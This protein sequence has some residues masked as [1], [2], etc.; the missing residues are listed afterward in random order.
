MHGGELVEHGPG[1]EAG[2]QR[3]EPCAQGDM[4]A[5][6]PGRRGRCELRY[7]ARVG[8]RS[9]V[10]ADHPCLY[11]YFPS[12]EVALEH[13][14]MQGVAGFFETEKAIAAGP[15]TPREKLAGLI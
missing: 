3:P 12:K 1:S 9:G 5:I 14:W 7:A 15:G 10:A 8:D 4:Q 2:R 13:V 11:Y 6:R